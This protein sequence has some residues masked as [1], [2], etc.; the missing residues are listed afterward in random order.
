MPKEYIERDTAKKIFCRL[1]YYTGTGKC[2][3]CPVDTAPAANVVEVRGIDT[4]IEK[5]QKKADEF[6]A[7]AKDY[8]GDG[9]VVDKFKWSHSLASAYRDFVT[10]LDSLACTAKDTEETEYV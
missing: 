1:C 6:F 5:Y 4:L 7:L 2:K 9:D 3:I 8:Y 10:D